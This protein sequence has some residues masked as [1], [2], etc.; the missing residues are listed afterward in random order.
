MFGITRAPDFDRPGLTW[1]NVEQPLTLADLKG[2]LV[3]LDFWTF[4]CINCFHVV[5]TLKKLEEAFPAE[6]AVIGVHSPKFDHEQ[7]AAF[8]AHAIAR[9]GITHA[10]VH[11]PH[12]HLWEDYCIRAWPTL[13]FISPDGYVIGEMAGEPHPDLLL[14]GI[15][16]MA[17]QFFARGELKPGPL[18][19]NPLI[20][21]GGALRFPGKIKPCPSVDGTKM[22]ALADTGHN[23]I[24][25]LEDDGTEIVR[26]G[27]GA[28]LL[29]DGG[30]EAAFNAPEGL[31]CD[32]TS[33]YVADTRNHAIRRIDR[34]SGQV[35]TL[36]GMGCRG[37]ILRQ[38]EPGSGVALSSP[39]DLEV[40][41]GVLYFANAGSHQIGAV[42]LTTGMVRPVAGTGGENI[43]DGDGDNALLAQPS[44]LSLGDHGRTLYFAD[45]ETSAVRRLCLQSGKV[46][47]LVGSGLFEFGHANGP[48]AEALLQHPLG[49]AA[50]DG[51]VYVADSYNSSVRFIDLASETVADLA[52]LNCVDRIC[53]PTAEPAGIAA[54]GPLRLLI[55]D[56]N[57]HRIME[58]L[59]DEGISRTWFE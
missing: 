42:D 5:P 49:V 15:G 2:R 17:K 36:A 23:Q 30:I 44:G 48:V 27:S 35:E 11:D 43:Q 16:D 18:K 29:R 53:R 51:R 37:V 45:S 55:S 21:L 40:Q 7:D 25:V 54:D 20:D 26:Y 38:P 34:A 8:V 24:V 13:V 47:T 57:N 4:C 22:W 32:E 1:F 41:G 19:L 14:Q 56:T 58:Y 10:V 50:V 6:L 33:I 39:W 52:A 59:L 28:A 12:M 3:V 9:Y 31:A 46:D